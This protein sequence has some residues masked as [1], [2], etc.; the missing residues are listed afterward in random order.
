M[1]EAICFIIILEFITPQKH[2]SVMIFIMDWSALEEN[3]C[4]KFAS[5]GRQAPSWEIWLCSMPQSIRL[6]I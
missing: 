6:D 1:V 3:A 4:K 5:D 2:F